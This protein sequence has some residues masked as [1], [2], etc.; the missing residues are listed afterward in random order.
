MK[1]KHELFVEEQLFEEV[2]I[3]YL[4]ELL[5]PQISE[6]AYSRWGMPPRLWK[7]LIKERNNK[8]LRG[9]AREYGVSYETVRRVLGR[10]E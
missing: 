10:I 6:I 9:I 1:A 2:Q 5:C 7:Q 3:A 8:S 4:V